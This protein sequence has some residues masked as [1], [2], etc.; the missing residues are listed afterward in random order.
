MSNE[1]S[2]KM[3]VGGAEAFS[4]APPTWRTD[5]ARRRPNVP[6]VDLAVLIV[7]DEPL[8]A[9]DLEAMLERRGA[10]IVG[11]AATVRE[12]LSLLQSE[13]PDVALLDF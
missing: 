13:R 8:I 11:P 10:R 5:P 7:E 1:L 4:A 2:P 12:A 9:L 6:Q 3:A